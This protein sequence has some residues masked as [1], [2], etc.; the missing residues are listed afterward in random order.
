MNKIKRIVYFFGLFL[1][2]LPRKKVVL[3]RSFHGQYNDSPKYISEELHKRDDSIRI[4]WAISDEANK[5]DIPDYVH[6]VQYN[7][8]KYYYYVY[9]SKVVVENYFGI[10]YSFAKKNSKFYD[11]LVRDTKQFNVSTWHGTPLKKIGI[12]QQLY[13]NK[14]YCFYSSSDLLIANSN[15]LKERMSHS[16]NIKNIELLGSPR[17][18][19][20]FKC[21]K[22][23]IKLKLGLPL[24]KKIVL[25]AP[26]FRDSVY[27]S[28]ERQLKEL[29]VNKL[30]SIF[31]KKF[32]GNHIFVARVHNEVLK[33]FDFSLI[34]N[35]ILFNGNLHDD[36]A[37][38]LAVT[39][40]LI[41]DYSGCFFDYLLTN[42]PCFLLTLDKENYEK[43]E[44]DFYIK[45]DELPFNY[46][47]TI[48]D[49]YR[50][51]G[52]FN[53]KKYLKE[54]NEFK[55]RIGCIDDGNSSSRVVDRIVEFY[56]K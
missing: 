12:D 40:I 31:N 17:N 5:K 46:A 29:D 32:G 16:Y 34:N 4:I 33:K 15:Y 25:F 36:M 7:S 45:L 30:V 50:I 11:F 27:E 43:K 51:I 48:E 54:L 10:I 38:Y 41:T 47:T 52:E 1:K 37:E 3:F 19:L 42:K 55:N 18:D 8:L 28:G 13:S 35:D 2:I 22:N 20:L 53:E 39:D 44:R 49:F 9:R 24:D 6:V 14:D 26:T 56:H 23:S 21:D